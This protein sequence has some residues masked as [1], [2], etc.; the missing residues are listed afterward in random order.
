MSLHESRVVWALQSPGLI[1]A[2]M[3]SNRWTIEVANLGDADDFFEST[4]LRAP[5]WNGLSQGV[6]YVFICSPLQF[7]RARASFPGAKIVQVAHQGYR[8]RVPVPDSGCP[9]VCFSKRNLLDL[10]RWHAGPIYVLTP[11]FDVQRTWTWK[12]ND[13][14]T[15][16]SRAAIRPPMACAGVQEIVYRQPSIS[17]KWYGQDNEGGFLGLDAMAA[18]R[19]KCSCYL[20]M[21][22]PGSGIGLTE[23]ECMAAGVPVVGAMH[24]ASGDW[25]TH[26]ALH[27]FFEFDSICN[28]IKVLCQRKSSAMHAS[29][30]G[31]QYIAEHHCRSRLDE[32]I[33]AFLDRSR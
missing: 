18:K 25:L 6:S 16:C 11:A 20:T 2:L 8:N 13:A 22:P 17:H 30:E 3:P 32:S 26:A 19:A 12:P 15:V 9:I 1:N 14:W 23:H 33:E 31:V 7:E 29:D 24:G 4:I 28:D 21:L 27:A 10:G 5:R